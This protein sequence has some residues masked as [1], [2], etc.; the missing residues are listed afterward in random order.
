MGISSINGRASV[1]DRKASKQF[2]GLRLGLPELPIR[3]SREYQAC[4]MKRTRRRLP[5][6]RKLDIRTVRGSDLEK[7]LRHPELRYTYRPSRFVPPRWLCR[8]WAW[9]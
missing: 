4:G 6:R 8:L 5:L 9:F 2:R 7:S 3:S 1:L